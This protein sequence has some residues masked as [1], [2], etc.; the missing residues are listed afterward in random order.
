MAESW[1]KGHCSVAQPGLCAS[2]VLENWELVLETWG[3]TKKGIVAGAGTGF[4]GRRAG[5]PLPHWGTGP[6]S[7]VVRVQ[8]GQASGWNSHQPR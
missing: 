1:A 5:Q 7:H 6:Q 8:V 3:C 2:L 4:L